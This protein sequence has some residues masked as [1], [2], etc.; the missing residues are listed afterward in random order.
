[1]P[2][3]QAVNIAGNTIPLSSHIKL[4]GVTLNSNLKSSFSISATFAIFDR[5]TDDT[6][7]TIA[8]FGHA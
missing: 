1:M 5:L 7:H 8:G 6:A 3:S 2:S 4:P